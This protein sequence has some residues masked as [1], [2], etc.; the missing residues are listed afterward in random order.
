MWDAM[1]PA[2][3]NHLWQTT[4]FA[5]TAGLLTLI[6]RKHYAR[7]RY[8]LWLAAS[9]KF[10]IPFSL[11][12][13]IGSH[14]A[15]SRASAAAANPGVYFA[16]EEISQP[17]TQSAAPVSSGV[18]LSTASPSLLHLLPGFIALWLCGFLAVLFVW[19]TRW[20]RISAAIKAAMPLCEGREV[21]ALRRIERIAGVRKPIGVLLS[22]ASLEPGIFGIARPIL[23]WPEGISQRL[24]DAPPRSHCCA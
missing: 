5:I 6:L 19:S 16:M 13:G 20:R 22:P 24:E 2:L 18:A 12:T 21:G 10:L 9:V 11:L 8:W 3:G 14:L 4:L 17:F 15:S 1:A 23:I 7:T